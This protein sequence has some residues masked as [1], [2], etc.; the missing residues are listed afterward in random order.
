MVHFH[1]NAIKR[2]ATLQ[3]AK[4]AA[5]TLSCSCLLVHLA[6]L[7]AAKLEYVIDVN[8]TALMKPMAKRQE[9]IKPHAW[10]SQH[11]RASMM[12]LCVCALGWGS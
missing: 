10:F 3:G 8:R 11:P 4:D 1:K 2:I 6:S 9:D 5:V 7:E 12:Y